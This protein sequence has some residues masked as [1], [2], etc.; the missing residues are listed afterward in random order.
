MQKWNVNIAAD[1]ELYYGYPFEG[2]SR[3]SYQIL[4]H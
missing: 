2:V 1:G 4:L 3:N